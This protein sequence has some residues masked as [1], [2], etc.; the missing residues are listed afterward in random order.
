MA[1]PIS[2]TGLVLSVGGVIKLL[3][4]LATDVKDAPAD[5]LYHYNQLTTE[6]FALKGAIELFESRPQIY[7]DR[8]QQFTEM[9][10]TASDAI[11]LLRNEIAARPSQRE[12]FTQRLTWHWKKA[13]LANHVARIERVKTCL[14]VGMTTNNLSNSEDILLHLHRLNL[15]IDE[16]REA[17]VS[18]LN[19]KNYNTILHQLAPIRPE[20][21]HTKALSDHQPGTSAWFLQG[22]LRQFFSNNQSHGAILWVKGKCKLSKRVS[23]NATNLVLTSHIISWIWEN[24]TFLTEHLKQTQTNSAVLHFYCSFDMSDSHKPAIILGSLVEQ[25]SKQ[26]P[27]IRE[28][29]MAESQIAESRDQKV[30][31]TSTRLE[32]ILIKSASELA[33]VTIVIDAI[34]EGTMQLEVE[35]SLYRLAMECP[36]VRVIASST[37]NHHM[38]A[39]E[40][41]TF[42]P[43]TTAPAIY[44][45][46]MNPEA[47]DGDIRAYLES[48][49]ATDAK[50]RIFSKNLKLDICNAI[51]SRSRG[52]FRY[53]ECQIRNLSAQKTGRNVRKAL[54]EIPP[55]LNE[56]YERALSNIKAPQDR[57]L[58]KKILTWLSFSLRPME[59]SEL[60]DAVVVEDGDDDI[61][62][63]IRL[64]EPTLLLENSNGLL[65]YDPVSQM[66]SLSHS[67]VKTFLTSD[68][69][70][71]SSV[72]DFALSEFACH[73]TIMRTCLTYLSFPSL[74]GMAG[75][76]DDA[77]DAYPLLDYAANYWPHHLHDPSSHDWHMIRSFFETRRLDEA[78]NYAVWIRILA[79]HMRLPTIKA[80]EPLY[81]AA[82]FG[83][84]AL[85]EAILC[86]DD[87]VDIE[88]RGG[89]R[90]STPLQA[91]CFYRKKEAVRMLLEAGADPL[92]RDGTMRG[93]FGRTAEDGLTSLWW[94]R[95]NGWADIVALIE[96]DIKEPVGFIENKEEFPESLA[97]SIQ[98]SGLRK[99]YMDSHA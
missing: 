23:S 95:L 4:G 94:A 73:K 2:I 6:L 99:Q 93:F 74:V 80:T 34:N 35:K 77:M 55:S 20:Q 50:L 27:A 71:T 19:Q 13:D 40:H 68:W 64:H 86:F 97:I 76:V 11:E 39:A 14:L 87:F 91:A 66:V 3:V 8:P 53:A 30:V 45:V 47:V 42:G 33:S 82:S 49:L 58:M 90:R 28:E 83:F 18:E 63:D 57:I 38:D 84:T 36:N 46:E 72:S 67:S 62:D 44:Q 12:R 85:I 70:R 10:R 48:K 79:D 89:R 5:T 75:N 65:E 29:L 25:L 51:L 9:L 41:T 60:G 43:R 61:D 26:V 37:D 21:A 15:Q 16:D 54:F 22:P 96:R 69:I 17:K 78:G 56:T 7:L 31:F 52:M 92:S 98:I 1:D 59:L 32:D 88:A 81:Y 24:D